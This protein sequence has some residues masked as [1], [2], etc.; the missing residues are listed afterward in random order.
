MQ[1]KKSTYFKILISVFVF[2]STFFIFNSCKNK[3]NTKLNIDIPKE[4]Y[5]EIKIHRYEK[6]LMNIDANNIRNELKKYKDEY[7]LFLNGN[8]D[9][10][11]NILQLYNYISDPALREIYEDIEKRYPDL[12]S[13]EKELSSAF[14]Y[15]KHY[16]PLKPTPKIYSYISYL[17]Y[18]NRII[19]VDT[20]MAIALDMYLGENYKMYPSVKIPKYISARLDSNYITI[21]CMKNIA[22]K[23]INFNYENKTLLDNILHL[24][25]ILYFVDAMIPSKAEELKIG[26][27][28]DQIDWCKKNEENIWAFFIKNNLLFNSDY[29]KIR[30]FFTEAPSTKGFKDAPPRF[31]E[32]IGWQIIKSYMNENK[33]ANLEELMKENDSQKILKISKYKP[34]KQ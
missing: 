17:D 24:G 3:N 29:F 30:Q 16:F 34:V 4:A 27:T 7:A 14:T 28:K 15:Y 5:L 12:S 2:S 6:I 19:N 9:D 13:L 33:N 18:E 1:T 11:L 20:V 23:T 26:Y 10:T 32:W 8:L 21:D 25:K 31:G 22:S